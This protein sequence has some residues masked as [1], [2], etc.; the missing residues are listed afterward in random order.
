MTTCG[1]TR[2]EKVGIMTQSW[3][4][5]NITSCTVMSSWGFCPGMGVTKTSVRQFWILQKYFLGYLNHIY[6]WQVPPQLSCGNTCQIQTW[7]SID[8][9]CFDNTEKSE[10][11]QTEEIGLVTPTLEHFVMNFWLAPGKESLYVPSHCLL[12]KCPSLIVS[13]G[14]TEKW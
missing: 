9:M 4:L 14:N 11:N 7:S 13:L 6:I 5:V 1:T 8:D 10:N 12:N 3:V 2:D